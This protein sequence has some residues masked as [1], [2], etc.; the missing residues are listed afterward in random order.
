M[1][2]KKKKSNS[3]EARLK[4][5]KRRTKSIKTLT[6]YNPTNKL[7]SIE[8]LEGYLVDIEDNLRKLEKLRD[9]HKELIRIRRR[10][11][12]TG[13][14]SLVGRIDLI[15]S[16]LETLPSTENLQI[17][18]NAMR[19]IRSLVRRYPSKKKSVNT[20]QNTDTSKPSKKPS[21][22]L[23]SSELADSVSGRSIRKSSGYWFESNLSALREAISFLEG[24][25]SEYQ[26][27]KELINRQ[28]LLKFA[29]ELEQKA[30]KIDDNMSDQ[31]HCIRRREM[32]F[33]EIKNA[34]EIA[35]SYIKFEYGENSKEFKDFK[36][37]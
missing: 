7:G 8:S 18:T 28:G 9:T 5:A 35:E 33:S 34:M 27:S 10:A 13:P 17:A 36:D 22:L 31:K 25:G 16:Y 3:A 4:R 30:Q 23:S 12:Y 32:A 19:S 24:M 2:A 20:N 15:L 1:A 14:T 21:N 29:K 6:K 37:V 26:P 11:H